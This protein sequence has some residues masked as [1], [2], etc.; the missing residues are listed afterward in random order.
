[1]LRARL[2]S[3]CWRC[4]GRSCWPAQRW[5]ATPAQTLSR[6]LPPYNG[7]TARCGQPRPHLTFATFHSLLLSLGKCSASKTMKTAAGNAA[8]PRSCH[9][10]CRPL[11][12]SPQEEHG[13]ANLSS[14]R[15]FPATSTCRQHSRACAPRRS[16][17]SSRLR[18][19]FRCR[20]LD[21]LSSAVLQDF[22]K[23]SSRVCL[24]FCAQAFAQE[25]L[26]TLANVAVK[27]RIA[28]VTSRRSLLVKVSM[29]GTVG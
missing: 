27:M 25:R 20:L 5:T 23:E 9:H 13:M 2:R 16:K 18:P 6:H 17:A 28:R 11:S 29:A 22:P 7:G 3:A 26:L 15:P 14:L 21:H 8:S 12:L 10:R 24:C 4:R 19:H 1:M